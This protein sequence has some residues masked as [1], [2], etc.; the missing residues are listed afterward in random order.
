MDPPIQF[1]AEQHV[2]D[3]LSNAASRAQILESCLIVTGS[4]LLL[5]LPNSLA[6]KSPAISW[7]SPIFIAL[8]S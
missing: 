7:K 6:S 4:S 2:K 1:V 5:H 3:R 8:I